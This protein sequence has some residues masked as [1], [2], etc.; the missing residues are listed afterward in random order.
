MAKN[1]SP[2]GAERRKLHGARRQTATL[3]RLAQLKAQ[4]P[5]AAVQIGRA[6][7]RDPGRHIWRHNLLLRFIQRLH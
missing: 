3:D 7:H 6:A 1:D 4:T 2:F 5:S